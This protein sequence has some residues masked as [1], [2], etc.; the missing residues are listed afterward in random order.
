MEQAGNRLEHGVPASGITNMDCL[1]GDRE[2]KKAYIQPEFD[3]LKLSS[4]EDILFNS[5]DDANA[6]DLGGVVDKVVGDYND[7]TDEWA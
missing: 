3:L 5:I 6:S 1:G 7:D 2:M 4:S